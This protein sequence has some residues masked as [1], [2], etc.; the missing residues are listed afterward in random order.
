[1]AAAL[2]T[3]V[4]ARGCDESPV[5]MVDVNW[6]GGRDGADFKLSKAKPLQ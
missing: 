2:A 1:V 5:A 4:A 3:A 6:P